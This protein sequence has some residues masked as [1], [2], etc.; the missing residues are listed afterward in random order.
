MKRNKNNGFT[1]VELLVVIAILAILGT[2]SIVGYTSFTKKA[3]Q[4]NALNEAIQKWREVTANNLCTFATFKDEV[5]EDSG[6]Y[7]DIDSALA[8]YNYQDKYTVTYD[9][10]NYEVIDYDHSDWRWGYIDEATFKYSSYSLDD[11]PK[12]LVVTYFDSVT[13]RG[14]SYLTSGESDTELYLVESNLGKNADFSSS[15]KITGSSLNEKGYCSHKVHVSDLKQ[16]TTYSYK[17]GGNNHYVYGVFK[18]DTQNKS[19]FRSIHFTDAQ[20]TNKD[21]LNIWENIFA[22]GLE[23]AGRK[24]DFITFAGDLSDTISD[25]G[26]QAYKYS[27]SRET[28]LPYN[29]SLP[30]MSVTGN[31]EPLPVA[32]GNRLHYRLNDIDF[33]VKGD[34]DNENLFTHGG[35][36]SFDYSNT[37]FVFMA[38]TDSGIEQAQLDWLSNDLSSSSAKWK[39]V[40]MHEGPYSTGDHCNNTNI[41][42][43]VTQCAPIFSQ[44]HVDLVLQGHDHTYN[45]SLPYRWDTIGYT[46]TYNNNSIVNLNP[47][48]TTINEESYDVNPNGTYYVTTGAAGHRVGTSEAKDVIYAEV[49]GYGGD[50]KYVP[51]HSTNT[52][53]TRKYKLELGQITQNNS[54]ESY[55][56]DSCVSDQIYNIGDPATGGVNAQMFGILDINNDTLSY[57]FY[58]VNENNVRLFDTLNI[59]KLGYTKAKAA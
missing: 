3:Y 42:N 36:Y 43:V 34:N 15:S 8:K 50:N 58:T 16:N 55:S 1:L 12:G 39:V 41:Q 51:V 53:T 28:M 7:Y 19:S 14:F 5:M 21:K 17:V 38:S 13:S 54:Y 11:S 57:K 4:S 46:E 49:N 6:W 29:S 35:F 24:L 18:T 9:G 45:K 32:E 33:G 27:L 44:Y 2:V 20:P 22:Q 48:T 40:T 31:H 23:T 10:K 56:Y 26:S 59:K 37:H 25:V 52:F 47:T 30:F